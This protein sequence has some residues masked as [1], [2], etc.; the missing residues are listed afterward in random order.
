MKFPKDSVWHFSESFQTALKK[1]SKNKKIVEWA[2]KSATH[3]QRKDPLALKQTMMFIPLGIMWQK[4]T[5]RVYSF[6]SPLE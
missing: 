3:V 4:T 5:T 1:G 2:K 6:A